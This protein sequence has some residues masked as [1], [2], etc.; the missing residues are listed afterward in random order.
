MR[1][2]GNALWAVIVG[3]LVA[4]CSIF[5]A[6]S[7]AG[8]SQP[9]PTDATSLAA[10]SQGS[11]EEQ[12]RLR[13]EERVCPEAGQLA[14]AMEGGKGTQ[15][16]TREA[17]TLENILQGMPTPDPGLSWRLAVAYRALGEHAKAVQV[18]ERFRASWG[19]VP[20][21]FAELAALCLRAQ[22]N[23]EGAAAWLDQAD[24]PAGL[25]PAAR[26][27]LGLLNLKQDEV[28][29]FDAGPDERLIQ[30]PVDPEPGVYAV[31]ALVAG[32]VAAQ[33]QIEV[34]TD[35]EP[36]FALLRVPGGASDDMLARASEFQRGDWLVLASSPTGPMTAS[37]RVLSRGQAVAGWGAAWHISPGQN[38][39]RQEVW[40]NPGE[41]TLEVAVNNQV[42]AVL[43][44]A[45]K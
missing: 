6:A 9:G 35:T 20:L 21:K 17:A 41:Y 31:R 8:A 27:Y 45:V 25:P 4:W 2:I 15:A 13:L 1:R 12:F 42:V 26:A 34:V 14:W 32:R 39:L 5:G 3:L 22:G 16:L 28:P 29:P 30:L 18:L 43:P 10:G 40:L 19:Y 23:P 24:S 37:W 11:A 38:Q 33:A 36:R 7:S 44:F